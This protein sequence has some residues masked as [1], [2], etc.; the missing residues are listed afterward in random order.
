VSVGM[1]AVCVGRRGCGCGCQDG[2][3]CVNEGV[4]VG[5]GVGVMEGCTLPTGDEQSCRYVPLTSYL[6][7]KSKP[8]CTLV[9]TQTQIHI[10]IHTYTYTHA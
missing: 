10:H 9:R 6:M 7:T 8:S 3:Q 4:G 5:V 1:W 2:C